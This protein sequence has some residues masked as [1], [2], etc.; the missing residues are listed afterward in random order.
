MASVELEHGA[1]CRDDPQDKPAD[2]GRARRCRNCDEP[3]PETCPNFC[4]H[5]GQETA[6]TPP[7]VGEFLH[8][9]GGNYVALE[10]TLW[11]TL[12]LLLFR[13]GELTREYWI[14]RKRRYVLPV[15]LYLTISLVA[16]ALMRWTSSMQAPSPEQVAQVKA[17]A[18]AETA[19]TDTVSGGPAG[20]VVHVKIGENGKFTCNRLP[21][22]VCGRLK[23][24]YELD[25]K[26]LA[27]EMRRL[28]DRFLGHWGSA[29]FV[30]V[31]AF[32]A[33]L[34]LVYRNRQ[35]RYAEHL[36]FALHLH[37]F[38]FALL[39]AAAFFPDT[40]A[41]AAALV[42]PAYATVAA[43]RAYGG[44]W[45]HTVLRMSALSVLY[46][47]TLLCALVLVAV[48]ALLE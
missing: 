8:Q 23:E 4:G 48:W 35:R 12:R 37:A 14:G 30:L 26:L 39:A 10:G 40:A 28:Q 22:W 24:R 41:E 7:T 18:M 31:P 32:A 21:D 43:K 15:R 44:R 25:S 38:W 42:A 19:S 16:L 3:L 20:L 46:G 13:P 17:E 27:A 34:T 11:R 6:L 33:W 1:Q 9:F 47:A 36:V 5:C 29:M 2:A 45:W